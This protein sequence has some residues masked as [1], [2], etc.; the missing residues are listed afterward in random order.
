MVAVMPT[1]V[2]AQLEFGVVAAA[3][4]QRL[5]D[6]GELGVVAQR[7][8]DGV[9]RRDRAHMTGLRG[10]DQHLRRAH[11][12]GARPVVG[13]RGGVQAMGDRRAHQ[14]VIGRVE[15]DLID[16]V[17]VTV[18]GVQD[19]AITVGQRTPALGLRPARDRAELGDLVQAPQ[20]A[21]AD[22]RFDQ[23]RRRRGVV[24]HQRPNL[25]GDHMR[26]RHARYCY[27]SSTVAQDCVMGHCGRERASERAFI[28][29]GQ[30]RAATKIGAHG[31][32]FPPV[33]V[34]TGRSTYDDLSTS[35][36]QPQSMPAAVEELGIPWAPVNFVVD[37][38][39][40]C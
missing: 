27:I 3:G 4:Q 17:P 14:L 35:Q 16:A 5:V 39:C 1:L 2:V 31:V 28:E 12:M 11:D 40:R 6:L 21:L 18:V 37:G 23:H 29:A 36:R 32:V 22:Q 19:R 10:P 30:R 15:F 38:A 20:P 9:G 7:G 26:I 25:I 8:N 24:I 34:A 13:P 33:T